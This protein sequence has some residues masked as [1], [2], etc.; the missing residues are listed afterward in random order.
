MES[1]SGSLGRSPVAEGAEGVGRVLEGAPHRKSGESVARIEVEKRR[2]LEVVAL[3]AGHVEVHQPLE[4]EPLVEGRGGAGEGDALGDGRQVG[5][6]PLALGLWLAETEVGGGPPPQVRR[7]T[8]DEVAAF[9]PQDLTHPR[10]RGHPGHD[11]N[12]VALEIDRR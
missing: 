10:L 5:R 3:R 7:A 6:R 9:R 2:G 11:T 12:K 1:R 4:Q 8:D